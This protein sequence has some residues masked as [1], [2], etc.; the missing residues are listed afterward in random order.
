MDNIARHSV[1]YKF[2]KWM[3]WYIKVLKDYAKFDGRATRQEYWIF[4]L[5]NLIILFVMGFVLGLSAAVFG[6]GAALVEPV[7]RIYYLAVMIPTIAVGVRRL[8]DVGRSGLWVIIPNVLFVGLYLFAAIG[9]RSETTATI[10]L[11]VIV[12]CSGVSFVFTLFDSQ[13]GENEYGPSPKGAIAS[14]KGESTTTNS[15]SNFNNSPTPPTSVGIKAHF[16]ESNRVD[17]SHNTPD[18]S[19]THNEKSNTDMLEDRLYAQIALEVESGTVEKSLWTK[20]YAQ[21]GGDE[22]QTRVQYIKTRFERL[23]AEE[24]SR[25]AA[26]RKEQE[27]AARQVEDARISERISQ[28]QEDARIRQ[29]QERVR[30][31]STSFRGK[32][33]GEIEDL[34]ASS[35]GKEFLS[36]TSWGDMEYITQQIRDNPLFLAVATGEGNTALHFAVITR[37]N[38]VIKLLID[39]GADIQI[40]NSEGKTALDIANATKQV[41]VAAF[42]VAATKETIINKLRYAAEQGDAMAQHRLAVHYIEGE[43]V[44]RDF[45]EAATWLRKS[46]LLGYA[47]SQ[48]LLGVM[49]EGGEGAEQDIQQATAYMRKAVEQGHAGAQAWLVAQEEKYK[50]TNI[51]PEPSTQTHTT[52]A[53]PHSKKHPSETSDAEEQ[54]KLGLKYHG[55]QGCPQDYA[56][57]MMWFHKAA[58]QG[59]AGAQWSLGIMY[60]YGQGV[61]QDYAQAA[62]WLHKAADQGV[63]QAQGT[64]GNMYADG[65]G[66]PQDY[67]QAMMWFRK[68]ADKGDAKAQWSLAKMYAIGEGVPQDYEQALKWQRKAADQGYS[69]PK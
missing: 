40:A 3:Y 39:E 49:H 33:T 1:S 54:Y 66:V 45:E 23:M 38:E 7:I 64:L 63:L 67:T 26:I 60:L 2:G 31:E 65:Q 61:P 44:Q 62:I 18:T 20:A 30:R 25:L 55:G 57:A 11:I 53:T 37:R 27:A 52:V 19:P 5:F 69:G 12:I 14:V 28:N 15:R 51:A 8:H 29:E 48:Y 6:V 58:D 21:A 59:N 42:L 10:L 46:A 4:F 43:D 22:K 32:T 68:A 13:P 16:A 41:E 50:A 36:R 47:E 35:E 56:Q 17:L 24:Q 34:A 9:I